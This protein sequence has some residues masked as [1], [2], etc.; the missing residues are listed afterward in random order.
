MLKKGT[1]VKTNHNMWTMGPLGYG[2]VLQ[3]EMFPNTY[4]PRDQQGIS[5]FWFGPNRRIVGI[6]PY[7]LEVIR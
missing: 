2:I 1:I 7:M 3:V 6:K 4:S 5:V